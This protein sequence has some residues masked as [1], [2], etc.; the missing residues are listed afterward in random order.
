MFCVSRPYS[1]SS[2]LITIGLVNRSRDKR[3]DTALFQAGFDV[4]VDGAAGA[5]A[6]LPYP[7]AGVV[8]QDDEEKSLD[9]L[10]RNYQTFAIGH[11]CAADWDSPA[12]GAVS[13][14]RAESLPMYQTPSI[15]ADIRRSDG[16][17]LTVPMAPLAGLIAGNDGH[18]DL[19]A[20]ID[21]YA[22]WI[23]SQEDQIGALDTAYQ[24]AAKRHMD[25]CR[26]MLV[27]MESGL[28][29]LQSDQ[30][31]AQAF[32]LSNRAVLLQQIRAGAKERKLVYDT[33]SKRLTLSQDRVVPDPL[34]PPPGRGSW[35]PFQIAFLLAAVESTAEPGHEDRELVDLIFFPTGG[36][37]TEAYLGLS[38]FSIFLRR[39]RNPAD[40]GTHILMRYTLRLLTSQQ[41]QRASALICAM[42]VIRRAMPAPLGS[43]PFRIGIWVGGDSTPNRCAQARDTLRDLRSG[44]KWA[45]NKFVVIRCPWC[46]A[47]IGPIKYE[48]RTPKG[49]QYLPGTNGAPPRAS[50]STAP[51][52]IASLPMR[53]R[54][55]SSTSRSSTSAP[56][57][58]SVLS[59]NSP[60]SPGIPPRGRCL[61]SA[62]P[63]NRSVLRLD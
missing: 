49:P 12:D 25:E 63:A 7:E 16:N 36:G 46:S 22:E 53:Y 51:M 50:P 9:L 21:G 33:R 43:E 39:L 55:W 31:A 35:R 19:Q 60:G 47:Q 61:A 34:S 23:R 45:E 18:R 62:M 2:V 40:T 14:V 5:G 29:Y 59:T 26:D 32:M 57:S 44:D 10:Y 6:V 17:T 56:I 8:D 20:V 52:P 4:R 1:E 13:V 28:R 27:R 42:E 3:D 30:V 54:C 15:T 38:A 24:S 48:G 37:K 58:S 41:F 11:G